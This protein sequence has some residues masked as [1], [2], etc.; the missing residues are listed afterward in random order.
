[1]TR[2]V[3]PGSSLAST[4]KIGEF[5]A[6]GFIFKDMVEVEAI[7]DDDGALDAC[8]IGSPTD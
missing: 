6:S 7:D 4:D 5:A 2:I 1:M 8:D 3:A